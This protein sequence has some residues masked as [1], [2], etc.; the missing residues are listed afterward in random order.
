MEQ[1]PETAKP[2]KTDS[3]KE[4]DKPSSNEA[5]KKEKTESPEAR[6]IALLSLIKAGLDEKLITMDDVY[7]LTA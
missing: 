7:K 4:C 5:G 2:A 1:K 6:K 3:P